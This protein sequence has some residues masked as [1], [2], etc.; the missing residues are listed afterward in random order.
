MYKCFG[1]CNANKVLMKK[2]VK[3]KTIQQLTKKT[4]E[5]NLISASGCLHTHTINK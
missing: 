1:E 2:Y 4:R 3:V 5:F